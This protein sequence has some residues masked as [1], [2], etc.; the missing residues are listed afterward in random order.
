MVVPERVP[1]ASTRLKR[2]DSVARQSRSQPAEARTTPSD[3]ASRMKGRADS[4]AAAAHAPARV[5]AI[6]PL[7]VV[8]AL[9]VANVG[10]ARGDDGRGVP[11]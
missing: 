1:F 2:Q 9:T 8:L 4:I 5:A 7:F 11:A 3:E 10:V 6:A